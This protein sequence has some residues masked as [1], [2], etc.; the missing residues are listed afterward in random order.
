MANHQA[1]YAPRLL[2]AATEWPQPALAGVP[3]VYRYSVRTVS[4]QCIPPCRMTGQGDQRTSLPVRYTM[5]HNPAASQ[6]TY[7]HR[8][9]PATPSTVLHH[10]K[11]P[12]PPTH[13]QRKANA[14]AHKAAR[15]KELAG[16]HPTTTHQQHR[17]KKPWSSPSTP[18]LLPLSTN[19]TP[20]I[21]P[22]FAAPPPCYPR[23]PAKPPAPCPTT[24]CT[25]PISAAATRYTATSAH[26]PETRAASE[27]RESS[28]GLRPGTKDSQS[29]G[30]GPGGEAA[31][32]SAAAKLPADCGGVPGRGV[33]GM[34]AKGSA[35][36]GWAECVQGGWISPWSCVA[37]GPRRT[38]RNGVLTATCQSRANWPI[39]QGQCL[40]GA[41]GYIWASSAHTTPLPQPISYTPVCVQS[42]QGGGVGTPHGSQAPRA[43]QGYLGAVPTS[44][45]FMREPAG[46][47]TALAAPMSAICS[48]GGRAIS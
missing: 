31:A 17:R 26:S 14:P 45:C 44:E 37:H 46:P 38:E 2:D 42:R 27:D 21:P 23:P 47:P 22:S 4:P 12:L 28:S 35:R 40:H 19:P 15:N 18:H 32:D 6:T 36:V 30:G 33:E 48:R 1:R 7:P 3:V 34:S 24:C 11:S 29:A 20:C 9:H 43:H 39:F 41:D 5:F 25:A 13:Q 10:Q 16:I 8:K